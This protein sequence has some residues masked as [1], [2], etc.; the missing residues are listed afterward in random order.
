MNKLI[1]SLILPFCFVLFL[2]IVLGEFSFAQT[3]PITVTIATDKASYDIGESVVMTITAVNGSDKDVT[4]NF[5]SSKQTDYVIDGKFRWSSDKYFLT[6]LTERT[7]PAHG[8]YSWTVI[9]KNSDYSLATGSHI[10]TSEVVG[11]GSASVQITVGSAKDTISP[12][13]IITSGPKGEQN[14][15]DVTFVF[16]GTDN[17][18]NTSNLTYSTYLQGYDSGWSIFS[19]QIS[20]T[21]RNLQNGTYTFFVKAE[22]EAGNIDP[23]PT[24]TDFSIAATK[25]LSFETLTDK[26]SYTQDE[27]IIVTVRVKNNSSQSATLN[28]PSSYQTDYVTDGKFRWSSDKVFAQALT[29]VALGPSEVKEWRFTHAPAQY[30]LQTGIHTV[31]GEIVGYGSASTIIN[32]LPPPTDV[33]YFQYVMIDDRNE[34]FIVKMTD[35]T[36]IQQA[37]D[38][39]SGA[40][41][42][43]VS[44]IV[45]S[46]NGGFNSP[47]SW[48]LDPATIILSEAFI[49]LCDA[50]PS[51]VEAHLA[52][53][54]GQ[55]YCPWGAR[56]NA[57]YDTPPTSTISA[58]PVPVVPATSTS[59]QVQVNALNVRQDAALSASKIG[60][61][62]QDEVLQ[63]LEEKSGWVKVQLPSGQIGWVFGQ[64][65]AP[66]TAPAVS[67]PSQKVIVTA[68]A[69]KV[70][71]GPGVNNKIITTV[72]RDNILEKVEEK[73]GWIK[74]ILTNGQSGWVY[75]K[76]VK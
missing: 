35:P 23:T 9:H 53:Q 75:G 68:W 74:I 55:R 22:D 57:V 3:F 25:N 37:L 24:S 5:S 31:I 50:R 60:L 27:N 59:I 41:R 48:H 34:W 69:L 43:I 19:S 42:L 73:S 32:I 44:G 18:S 33:R 10:I 36:T 71:S 16:S 20:K 1:K 14:S 17:L 62:R 49:E 30:K 64:Y 56:V 15:R 11:Y 6:V 39:L 61:V 54:L 13:A 76:F 29:S 21:Y 51:Y 72:Q 66:T 65:V 67:T 40:R 45:N 28:F 2:A 47:W 8:E 12:D 58:Q 46:G 70:R 7:V 63:K 26:S 52:E 38:D 4:L